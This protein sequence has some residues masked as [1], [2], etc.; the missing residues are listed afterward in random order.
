MESRPRNFTRTIAVVDDDKD[1]RTSLGDL[2][3]SVGYTALIF[4]SAD[5]FLS[6][7]ARDGVDCVISDIQMKG[8]NGLEL[9]RTVRSSNTPI[10]LITAFPTPEISCQAKSAGVRQLLFKPFN[11]QA[12]I[13]D[14]QG[15]FA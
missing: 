15:I 4:D 11:S 10:I 13:D 9:A 5:S 2:L 3:E 7:D 12:L 14:L 8:M 6:S 1:L